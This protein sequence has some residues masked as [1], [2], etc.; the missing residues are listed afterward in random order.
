MNI[1]LAE[2][3]ASSEI[4]GKRIRMIEKSLFFVLV[5]LLGYLGFN[6]LDIVL[7]SGFAI[8]VFY[9]GVRAMFNQEW[10]W[11]KQEASGPNTLV[12]RGDIARF[13]WLKFSFGL[14]LLLLAGFFAYRAG[15]LER[16][17]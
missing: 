3:T 14:I 7:L 9:Q 4:F 15:L 1:D 2:K 11:H 5:A 17:G 8:Y 6:I 13:V 16:L 10:Y 12:S